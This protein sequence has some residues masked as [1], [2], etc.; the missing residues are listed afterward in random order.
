MQVQTAGS[1]CIKTKFNERGL[2]SPPNIFRALQIDPKRFHEISRYPQVSSVFTHK[3]GSGGREFVKLLDKMSFGISQDSSNFTE[4]PEPTL[5][6]PPCS[7][8]LQEFHRNQ[9]T[10]EVHRILRKPRRSSPTFLRNSADFGYHA[11]IISCSELL[12]R[13]PSKR[14]SENSSIHHHIG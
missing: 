6:F 13:N 2:M 7:P 1:G 4:F 14:S 3:R 9:C 11:V 12:P 10:A 8:I 5:P